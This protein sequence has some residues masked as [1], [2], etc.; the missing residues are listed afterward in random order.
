MFGGK[1]QPDPSLAQVPQAVPPMQETKKAPRKINFLVVGLAIF[2][3]ILLCTLAGVGYWAYTL[4]TKL[5]ATKGELATLHGKYD[6]LTAEKNKLATDLDTT[7]ASLEQTKAELETTKTELETTKTEL[8]TTKSD[9]S[10]S[11]NETVALQKKIDNAMKYADVLKGMFVDNDSFA[12]SRN[13]IKAT[14]DSTLL[15]KFDAFDKSRSTNDFANFLDYLIT[16]LVESL[17]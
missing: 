2:L 10:N 1:M 13:R 5:N 4:N 12:E 7:T 14:N 17:K 6:S 8:S 15:S 16:N 9:L 11:K 3:V